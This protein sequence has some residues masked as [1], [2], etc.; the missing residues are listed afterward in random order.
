MT[1]M[2]VWLNSS[3]TLRHIYTR[4]DRFT[5]GRWNALHDIK[6]VLRRVNGDRRN[7][8]GV[9]LRTWTI[10]REYLSKHCFS[11]RRESV[12]PLLKDFETNGV[13]Q[14]SDF[15]SAANTARETIEETARQAEGNS[16][17][18]EYFRAISNSFAHTWKRRELNQPLEQRNRKQPRPYSV[19]YI[20]LIIA[21]LCKSVLTRVVTA[22]CF[23]W[24]ESTSSNAWSFSHSPSNNYIL[25]IMKLWDRSIY[26]KRIL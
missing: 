18:V 20:N 4:N 19:A 7:I 11:P 13:Y 2:R 23:E 21:R 26:G 1:T 22:N 25:Y 17:C 3:V 14:N 15:R 6:F 9:L 12:L 8:C 10:H 16:R 5:S 24:I